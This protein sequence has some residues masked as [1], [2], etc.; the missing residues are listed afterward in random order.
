MSNEEINLFEVH[1]VGARLTHQP[2]A[3][4]PSRFYCDPST[5][6]KFQG[7]RMH[8]EFDEV[9]SLL[10]LWADW[11]RRPESLAEGYPA[12][13]SGGFIESWRKDDEDED[14]ARMAE[15]IGRINAAFDSLSR[16]YQDAITR[17]YKL[18]SAVWQFS[19]PATFDDAKI[20]LRVKL[21]KRG[22]L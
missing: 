18:G 4:M 16:L 8:R 12:K 2:T 20:V 21:V 17:H 10:D 7:E 1:S 11:M 13:A 5:T 22:L 3:A 6:A 19:Q 14:E 9:E 15:R